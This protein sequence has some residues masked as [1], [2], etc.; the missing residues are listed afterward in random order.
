MRL[1]ALYRDRLGLVCIEARHEAL[2]ADFDGETRR[3]CGLL[4]LDWSEGL[5]DFSARAR[6]G[7][8]GSPSAPLLARGLHRTGAGAWRRYASWLERASP[9]LTPWIDRFGYPLDVSP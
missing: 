4:G 6:Q 5:R 7:G 1:C 3:L 2:L 9:W 8:V